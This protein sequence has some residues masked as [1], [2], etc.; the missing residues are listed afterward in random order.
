MPVPLSGSDYLELLP[1][2]WQAITERGIRLHHRTYNC[3]LLGP[4]RGQDCEVAARGG[5]WEIH[6]NPHD[7][8]QIWVRLPRHGL[9]E[10]P[11]IHRDHCHQPF[12][13]RTWQRL[14][15][16][17]THDADQDTYEARLADAL[18]QLMRRA[19]RIRHPHRAAPP[20]PHHTHPHSP[21]TAPR[22]R[23]TATGRQDYLG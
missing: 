20:R 12:N 5:K 3:D 18:D 16:I 8:R 17:T 10:I 19:R 6:T 22:A 11:W 2:R 4:Y 15:T 14:K 9:T 23:R 13:D 21:T 1:V 7:V